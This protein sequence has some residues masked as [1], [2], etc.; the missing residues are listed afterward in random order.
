VA[1]KV[2]ADTTPR[3]LFR[4]EV[5]IW[6]TLK[7]P[8]VL[9]LYGASSTNCDPP[10]F[11]VSPYE[12]N[13]SLNEFLKRIRSQTRSSGS[14]LGLGRSG[15]PPLL[16]GLGKVERQATFPIWPGLNGSPSSQSRARPPML[17]TEYR[18]SRDLHRFICEIA[19][20]ME[21]LHSQSVQ[22]G[23]LKASFSDAVPIPS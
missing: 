23:D 18:R 20:G 10:W 16:P 15:A 22:H 14:S 6:K 11:F 17:D 12:K 4:R 8:N 7:H 1:I 13:G 5:A 21:Y 19:K 2:L 3:E 9:E